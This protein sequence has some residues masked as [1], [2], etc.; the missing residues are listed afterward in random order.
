MIKNFKE[1]KVWQKA[2]ILVLQVYKI[3]QNFPAR[4]LYCLTSQ[5]RRAAISIA[6]NIVEGKKRNTA[7]DF[8][9]F[10]NMADTSLE[11]LKYYFILSKDLEYISTEKMNVLM[12]M[13][14]EVGLM[15]NGLEKVLQKYKR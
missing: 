5:M 12:S 8:A 14:E 7:N 3:T 2:H 10:I 11:E 15:L 4:E 13:A 6:A 9:H 1:L